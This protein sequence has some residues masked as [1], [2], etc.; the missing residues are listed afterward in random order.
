[1][2]WL[3]LALSVWDLLFTINA[4]WPSRNRVLLG[5]SFFAS[6]LTIELAPFHLALQIVL[7]GLLVW[8]GAL[9]AWPGWLGLTLAA[10]SWV[11]LFSMVLQG[12]RTSV[13]LREAVVEVT[14]ESPGPRVPMSKV[15]F[16]FAL[17][18]KGVRRI[19]DVEF[20]RA[21]GRHQRLDV[22]LPTE[23]RPTD[24]RPAVLQIHGGAWVI[25][26]KREQGL[27]LLNHLAANGWVC[28]NANY[29]LSPFA[30]WPDHL[31]DC[32]RALAFIREHADEYG[33]D[34]DFVCVTGGSAGGHLTAL[35]ALT[36]NDP[37]YQPG[38]EDA[39][40]T[41]QAAVPFYGVY[42]FTNRQGGMHEKFLGM[43]LEPWVMK[44]SFADEPEKFHRASPI[45]RVHADAPP[46]LAIHG[47]RD[48]LAPVIDAR[49]FV[50]RLREV[51]REPVLYAELRGAQHA[52]E[53]FGSV[54]AVACVE[55][56]ERFLQWA[57]ERH[58]G[59]VPAEPATVVPADLNE[60]Q[61]SATPA[62]ATA[63]LGVEN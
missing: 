14:G 51:S 63:S 18:R 12:R 32:K 8:F 31:V 15:V 53:I 41:L 45:D 54:R 48:T 23:A 58:L 60:P 35:M 22:Y 44:A 1:M 26:D 17:K 24:R 16:P 19:K 28:F 33:I 4:R 37:E 43:F 59:T 57:H 61:G 21:G 30:T 7:V 42:D 3:L 20:G 2:P 40:T 13:T 25:G 52:F 11:G 62:A 55:A 9:S 39:D 49:L 5:P 36:A 34:P 47:D 50:E 46:F 38:F 29:R 56:A 27:P 10:V 6:W